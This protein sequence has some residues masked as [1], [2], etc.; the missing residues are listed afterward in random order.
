MYPQHPLRRLPLLLMLSGLLF[1]ALFQATAQNLPRPVYPPSLAWMELSTAHYTLLF[2]KGEEEIAGRAAALLEASREPVDAGL[3][4]NTRPYTVVLNT[5]RAEAN[6]YATLAPRY[7]EWYT[8]ASPDAFAGPVDWLTLLALHEG[9]HMAQ[10]DFLDRGF[11][12][13]AGYAGGEAARAA[14]SFF[15]VPLW[16]WEGDAIAAE[17][18]LSEGGRGRSADFHRQLRAVLGEGKEVSYS[19]A[20]LGTYRFR[21]PNHYHLGFPLVAYG[22]IAHGRE[23]WPKVLDATAAFSFWPLRFSSVLEEKTGSDASKFYRRTM[24]YLA[25]RWTSEQSDALAQPPGRIL[26]APQG[27]WRDY[28]LPHPA[29]DGKAALTLVRGRDASTRL[30]KIEPD[31]REQTLRLLRPNARHID[32]IGGTA[33]WSETFPHPLWSSRSSSDLL[34][35]DISQNRRRRLTTGGS[36]YSPA[37]SP[38]GDRIA[39]V[40]LKPGGSSSIVVL[41]A[42]T[43][44]ELGTFDTGGRSLL[45]QPAWNADGSRIAA[46]QQHPGGCGLVEFDIASGDRR[47]LSS[48][49]PSGET[50]RTPVYAGTYLV[51]VSDYSGRDEIYALE[52]STGARYRLISSRYGAA[53]PAWDEEKRTLYFSDYTLHGYRAVAAPMEE[54]TLEPLTEVSRESVD[55]AELLTP[56]ADSPAADGSISN[57]SAVVSPEELR[58]AAEQEEIPA[59]EP[60]SPAAHLLN[61]HSWG[62]L[63]ATGGRAEAFLLSQDVLRSLQLRS[64]IGYSHPERSL[65]T[66]IQGLTTGTLPMLRFGLRGDSRAPWADGGKE[67]G[68]TGHAGLELPFDFSGGLWQRELRLSTTA[69]LRG[70]TAA[71]TG[72]GLHGEQA[73]LRHA[74]SL[75]RASRAVTPLDFAPPWRQRLELSYIHSLDLFTQLDTRVAGRLD[76]TAPGILPH[77]RLHTAL[78]AEQLTGTDITLGYTRFRPRGYA[79]S[80]RLEAPVNILATAEYSAPLFYPDFSMGE[81][82]YL[83]RIRG[84]LFYDHGAGVTGGETAWYRSV[85]A[86][87]LFQQHFFSLPVSIEFGLSGAYRLKDGGIRIEETL[88]GFS[89]EW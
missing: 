12:R 57:S 59:A 80:W 53:W 49:G 73:P 39:A 87:L 23:L 81:L 56:S 71:G 61:V 63:P 2:P 64:F 22:R 75:S 51:Y 8:Y 24:E 54:L 46:V 29:A 70:S 7:S 55:Y 74:L 20:Y 36:F 38:S 67:Y 41:D 11:N 32:V 15:S 86:E 27:P 35:Y 48:P 19:Q 58:R 21:F 37:L 6:G 65:D 79:Y 83:K 13:I 30:V 31:G 60:Y 16:F 3:G 52:R 62:I 17:T 77:H 26:A 66:G 88:L 78:A 44:T 89:L 50:L 28:M 69:Y 76:L 34:R 45:L 9:R 10:F 82:Y 40:S 4:A 72:P 25:E 33:V 18:V 85:G 14:F 5:G 42:R 1:A 47:Q 84:T 43:G 68:L